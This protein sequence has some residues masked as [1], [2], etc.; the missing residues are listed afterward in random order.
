M[1]WRVPRA[2]TGRHGQARVGAGRRWQALAGEGRCWQTQHSSAEQSQMVGRGYPSKELENE[3]AG[4]QTGQQ[5]R[6]GSQ[7]GGKAR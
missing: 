2:G 5:R 7:R 3:G 4:E 6:R 1:A